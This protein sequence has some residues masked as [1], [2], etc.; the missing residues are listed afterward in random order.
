MVEVGWLEE[1]AGMGDKICTHLSDFPHRSKVSL[2]L[3][4]SQIKTKSGLVG[5]SENGHSTPIPLPT[6]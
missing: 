4:P 6:A 3:Q 5:K 2:S 1:D